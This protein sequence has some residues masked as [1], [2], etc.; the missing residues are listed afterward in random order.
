MTTF[1]AC[2]LNLFA[3]GTAVAQPSR[4]LVVLKKAL[5]ECFWVLKV[6]KA[7]LTHPVDEARHAHPLHL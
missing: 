3:A 1:F 6:T 2:G 7:G 5:S 4:A